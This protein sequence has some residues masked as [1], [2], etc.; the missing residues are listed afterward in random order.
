MSNGR[1]TK[2]N[3]PPG[4][5]S[6]PPGGN[7]PG[8]GSNLTCR[9]AAEYIAGLLDGLKTIAH[10]AGLPFIAYLLAMAIEEAR[11]ERSRKE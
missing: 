3:G 5:R 8:N 1:Q 7:P 11:V 2:Q 4:S 6:A 10:E 9:E